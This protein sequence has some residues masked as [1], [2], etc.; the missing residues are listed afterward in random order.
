MVQEDGTHGN[1]KGFHFKNKT[2]GIVSDRWT[3]WQERSCRWT[4]TLTESAKDM[5][6]TYP[7]RGKTAHTKARHV[8]SP[9]VSP[10][11]RGWCSKADSTKTTRIIW[12]ST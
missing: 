9:L 10:N 11:P 3:H 1:N 7:R 4:N 2:K 12:C 6:P 5:A 8:A